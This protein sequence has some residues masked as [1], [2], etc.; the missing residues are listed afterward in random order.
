[1][2]ETRTDGSMKDPLPEVVEGRFGHMI[3]PGDAV[4]TFTQ[5]NRATRIDEGIFRG[6]INETTTTSWGTRKW[7]YYV[8]E[9]PD[10]RRS[11]LQYNGMVP[12]STK[13]EELIGERV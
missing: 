6:V 5:A 8:V 12:R 9:R 11:K 13:L 7:T 2:Y 10:G 4:I 1:M 3:Q